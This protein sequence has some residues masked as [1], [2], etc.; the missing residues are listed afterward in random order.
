MTLKMMTQFNHNSKGSMEWCEFPP[1]TPLKVWRL[2]AADVGRFFVKSEEK[3]YILLETCWF[4]HGKKLPTNRGKTLLN[5]IYVP[6]TQKPV[7]L[8]IYRMVHK[9]LFD[10]HE[11]YKLR[12][13]IFGGPI[14]LRRVSYKRSSTMGSFWGRI[15]V[16][17]R[18]RNLMSIC[19]S[20][21]RKSCRYKDLDSLKWC[22][23][24]LYEISIS[25]GAWLCYKIV[26]A[27]QT[28][29]NI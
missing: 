7:I 11:R 26:S 25:N 22:K 14:W 12:I 9:V 19:L 6:D 21:F 18:W 5:P 1:P 20:L 17:Y 2:C 29:T 23:H 3:Y 13:L 27:C 4:G 28:T 16:E 24:I 10:T 15:S 8:R